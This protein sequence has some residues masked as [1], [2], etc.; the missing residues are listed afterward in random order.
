MLVT[1]QYFSSL[2]DGGFKNGCFN[3][4]IR[5]KGIEE[6]SHVLAAYSCELNHPWGCA[7]ASRILQLGDGVDPDNLL[8]ELMN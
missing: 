3:L 6:S 2:C 1:M 8:T 7:N 4:S 5:A